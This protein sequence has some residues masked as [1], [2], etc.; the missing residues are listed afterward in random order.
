M[1]VIAFV[2]A[3]MSSS[4][5][6]GKVLKKII[7]KPMLDHLI[8]RLSYSKL[9]DEVVVVTSDD[10]S[11]DAIENLCCELKIKFFRG[12]L[13]NV[14]ERF[15]L[16]SKAYSAD[17]IVRITGDCPLLDSEIVDYI[18]SEHLKSNC[19]YTSNTINPSYPDGQD[20][21]VFDVATLEKMYIQAESKID[22]EHVTFYCYTHPDLFK[23][24]NIK[25]PRGDFS[26]YRWTVDNDVDFLFVEKIYEEL[27]QNNKEFNSL[28][29]YKLL[30]KKPYLSEINKGIVR[31]EGL[32]TS[33]E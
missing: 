25:N 24:N 14:L 33:L 11:D 26:T 17:H 27:Y 6:P 29:I 3:R 15:Y 23:L 31:N 22:Q 8:S 1:K 18:I 16:A 9:I 19:N 2:Q 10:D 7:E 20:V 32:K 12:S 28:D 21:E 30:D 5:L 4:R 13:D